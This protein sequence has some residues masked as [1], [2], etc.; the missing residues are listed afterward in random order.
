MKHHQIW[1]LLLLTCCGFPETTHYRSH[2]IKVFPSADQPSVSCMN[3]ALDWMQNHWICSTPTTYQHLS[4]IRWEEPASGHTGFWCGYDI[5][6]VTGHCHGTFQIVLPQG[7]VI[8]VVEYPDL[9]RS[10]L[11]HELD[12]YFRWRAGGDTTSHTKSRLQCIE[13]MQN[14]L[15]HSTDLLTCRKNSHED[16]RR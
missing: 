10:A 7:A 2:G 3:Q 6:P 12:H 9:I 5:S 16:Y 1:Y 8:R 15:L 14:T 4:Q 13:H 11:W